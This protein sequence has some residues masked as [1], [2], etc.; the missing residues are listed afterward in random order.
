MSL[1]TETTH[2]FVGTTRIFVPQGMSPIEPDYTPLSGRESG[3]MILWV[4][5]AVTV[6]S[7]WNRD[8]LPSQPG[9][10]GNPTLL[11]VRSH[12]TGLCTH[13]VADEVR[14]ATFGENEKL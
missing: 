3:E 14:I 4:G 5:D 1:F 2:P 13:V 12:T 10:P 9:T 11:Y 6:L 7:A 8:Y